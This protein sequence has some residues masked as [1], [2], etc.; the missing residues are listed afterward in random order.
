MC[1][2]KARTTDHD[3]VLDVEEHRRAGGR[4]AAGNSSHYFA[5]DAYAV[6]KDKIAQRVV[7]LQRNLEEGHMATLEKLGVV[8]MPSASTSHYVHSRRLSALGGDIDLLYLR[9]TS[10]PPHA[11][12]LR[13]PVKM[14]SVERAT[15]RIGYED[16]EVGTPICT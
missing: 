13:R 11:P 2:R 15:K 14:C 10:L 3:Y 4:A 1:A 6:N 5:R 9:M 16:Q 7:R 12:A 8:G